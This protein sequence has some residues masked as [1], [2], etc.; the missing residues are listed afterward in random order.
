M[1]IDSFILFQ[2]ITTTAH[3]VQAIQA[4]AEGGKTFL[5]AIKLRSL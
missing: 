1:K 4:Q 5:G 2:D 3:I